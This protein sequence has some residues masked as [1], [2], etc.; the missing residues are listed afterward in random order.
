MDQALRKGRQK[1]PSALKDGI[2]VRERSKKTK[3]TMKTPVRSKSGVKALVLVPCLVAGWI[4]WHA[5]CPCS[6]QEA[7][8]PPNLGP[9]LQEIAKLGQAHMSD[10][11]ILSYV[12]WSG[13]FYTLRADD[14]IY[15]K[16]QGISQTV[17]NALLETKPALAAPAIPPTAP[18]APSHG[19]G[20]ELR[21]MLLLKFI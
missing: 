19:F 8:A 10:E 15:L 14:I 21:N 4:F 12:Q 20:T 17:I 5:G 13:K 2:Q 3:M 1:T 18:P 16:N 6:A 7:Q 11:V 9:E